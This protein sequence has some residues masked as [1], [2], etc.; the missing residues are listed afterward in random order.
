MF[1]NVIAASAIA[2]SLAACATPYQS[3]GYS[4]G[5]DST[6]LSPNTL[7]VRVNGNGYTTADRVRDYT[8]LQAAERALE[9]G[10]SHFVISD[11]RDTSSRENVWVDTP[12]TTTTQG[13]V[14]GNTYYGTS[15]TTG[16]GYNMPVFRPSEDTVFVMFEG[17]PDGYRPGQYF[18]AQDV[19]DELAPQYIDD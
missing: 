9:S 2:L 6:W 16:G 7:A 12:T 5:F 11:R 10:Y 4:G 1:R 17:V 18:V 15:T 19:Y 3:M 14:Y 8:M 13:S